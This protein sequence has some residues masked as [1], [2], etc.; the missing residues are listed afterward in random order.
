MPR[1]PRVVTLA[2]LVTLVGV[3][4]VLV[5]GRAA[6]IDAYVVCAVAS[7]YVARALDLDVA[8]ALWSV[9]AIFGIQVALLLFVP[10]LGIDLPSKLYE[11]SWSLGLIQAA[12]VSLVL[13]SGGLADTVIRR[14]LHRRRVQADHQQ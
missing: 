7:A 11:S 14:L 2:V 9:L 10:G 3:V 6:L 1:I 8:E 5:R 4:F 12:G 13:G